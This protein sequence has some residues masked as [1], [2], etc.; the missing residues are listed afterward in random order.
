M[1]ART[2]AL[3]AQ[4]LSLPVDALDLDAAAWAALEGRFQGPVHP[5]L[6][7]VLSDFTF[8]DRLPFQIWLPESWQRLSEFSPGRVETPDFVIIGEKHERH[9]PTGTVY[10]L[11][12]TS[13]ADTGAPLWTWTQ[14]GAPRVMAAHL[15][16]H[17]AVAEAMSRIWLR[18]SR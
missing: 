16:E 2:D 6:R 18:A 9:V 5:A 11:E 14:G 13:L 8:T 15:L 7:R 12:W 4:L 17:A 1:T 3:A 10:G